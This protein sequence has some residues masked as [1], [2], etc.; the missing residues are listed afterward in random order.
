MSERERQERITETLALLGRLTPPAVPVDRD[1]LFFRAGEASANSEL[2]GSSLRRLAWPA[3]AATL[4]FL[5][6]GLGYTVA[7]REPEIQIVYVERPLNEPALSADTAIE[8]PT[9]ASSSSDEPAMGL[10]ARRVHQDLPIS[11]EIDLIHPQDWAALS[12]A[13]A[14]QLRSQY[15][16]GETLAS[17]H[18]SAAEQDRAQTFNDAPRKQPRTYLELR[19]AMRAM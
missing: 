8:T 14:Q 16:Q 18:A 3:F 2:A 13:F 1:E 15:E 10:V 4:A 12:D 17:V 19:D 6:A 11:S 9:V 7:D 5:G